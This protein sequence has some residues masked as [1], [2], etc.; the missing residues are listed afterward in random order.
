MDVNA[1]AQRTAP[2]GQFIVDL[3]E[4][5]FTATPDCVVN[6]KLPKKKQWPPAQ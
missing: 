1:A 2:S 6:M 4:A 3:E 5:S